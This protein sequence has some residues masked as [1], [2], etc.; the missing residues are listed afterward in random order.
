[1]QKHKKD[2]T[3]FLL[4]K[5][6][7]IKFA[8][9]LSSIREAV[10]SMNFERNPSPN[11]NSL[12]VSSLRGEIIVIRSLSRLLWGETAK[13]ESFT[14][15]VE[16]GPTKEG[17]QIE[18]IERVIQVPNEQIKKSGVTDE[19]KKNNHEISEFLEISDEIIN[20][21]ELNRLWAS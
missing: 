12:G 4:Y 16:N 2:L 1:M 19:H 21:L 13:E 6:N 15:I 9:S 10:Q 20:V 8:S 17:W 7:N 18:S 5:C 3:K 11:P 14:L